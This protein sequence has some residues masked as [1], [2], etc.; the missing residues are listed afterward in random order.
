VRGR[1]AW[2]RLLGPWGNWHLFKAQGVRP[3]VAQLLA[4]GMQG[5]RDARLQMLSGLRPFIFTLTVCFWEPWPSVS[6][7]CFVC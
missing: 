2:R 4:H 7:W 6:T 3:G 5:C 1:P